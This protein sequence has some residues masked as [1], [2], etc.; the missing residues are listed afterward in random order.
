MK[1][2]IAFKG[3]IGKMPPKK[4]TGK[5]KKGSNGVSSAPK[6]P[7]RSEKSREE[8]KRDEDDEDD[9]DGSEES[10]EEDSESVSYGFSP[11]GKTKRQRFICSGGV[12][13]CGERVVKGEAGIEC[14]A[15]REWFHAGCQ[16]MSMKAYRALSKY[17]GEFLWLCINCKPNLMSVLKVGK[18]IEKR[19]EETEKKI[20]NALSE[21]RETDNG[22]KVESCQKIESRINNMEAKLCSEIKEKQQQIEASLNRQGNSTKDIKRLVETKLDTEKREN[23]II[24]HNIKE[25]TADNPE[26]RVEHDKAAFGKVV[27]ALLGEQDVEVE[28]IF[29]LGKRLESTH[30]N[31]QTKPRLLLIKV[32]NKEQVDALMKKRTQLRGKGFPNV[33]L[34]RDLTPE[35]RE[36]QKKLRLELEEKGRDTHMIFRGRVIR[37]H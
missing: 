14:D 12:K 34:T 17:N 28:R 5:K 11:C 4:A 16:G 29:R 7:T 23:N 30:D 27:S 9:T 21:K 19:L 20:L 25:S 26:D 32:R 22:Q 33:Y 18:A 36:V 13:A 24:L 37:R 10:D 6:T 31:A 15:C 8:E 3:K 35:E 1:W 2:D